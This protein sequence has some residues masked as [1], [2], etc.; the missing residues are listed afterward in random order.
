MALTIKTRAKGITIPKL[1]LKGMIEKS[2]KSMVANKLMLRRD[3]FVKW[4]E[5]FPTYTI[6][7]ATG[8]KTLA[9]L[10]M[11]VRTHK[12]FEKLTAKEMELSGASIVEFLDCLQDFGAIEIDTPENMLE[13]I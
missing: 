10:L 13:L 11:R 2:V 12:K 6:C 1:D 8:E 4:V 3:N 5:Y 9:S 7:D